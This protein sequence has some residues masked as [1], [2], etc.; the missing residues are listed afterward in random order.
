MKF[1]WTLAKTI[2]IHIEAETFREFITDTESLKQWKVG[3][4]LSKQVNN[5]EPPERRVVLTHVKLL[6][7]GG[8]LTGIDVRESADGRLSISLSANPGLSLAGISLL[9][10]LRADGFIPKLKKFA[11]DNAVP[12]TLETLKTLSSAFIKN[13]F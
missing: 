8:F 12:L 9:E 1:D 2:L 10:S 5:S 7:D 11:Q 3:Q 13:M 4:L 6:R